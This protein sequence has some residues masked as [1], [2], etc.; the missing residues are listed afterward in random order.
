MKF[1]QLDILVIGEYQVVV[2]WVQA[3]HVTEKTQIGD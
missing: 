2:R 1:K 3:F